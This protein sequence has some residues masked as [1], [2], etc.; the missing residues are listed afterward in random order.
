M[1]A[2]RVVC[3]PISVI[4]PVPLPSTC[5]SEPLV[6]A[7]VPAEA[8][9]S[10]TIV[11]LLASTSATLI[12]VIGVDLPWSTFCVASGHTVMT[13]LSLTSLTAIVTSWVP[14]RFPSLASIRIEYED[15]VS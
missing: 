14:T 7:N 9:K 6:A 11:S 8:D 1:K 4:A 3:R 13:G 12:P 10:T 5:M 15:L 2:L